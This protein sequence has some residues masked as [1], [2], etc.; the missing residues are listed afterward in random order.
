[1]GRKRAERGL[2]AKGVEAGQ[3]FL[4]TMMLNSGK[5]DEDT[6]EEGQSESAFCCWHFVFSLSILFFDILQTYTV[7][8]DYPCHLSSL[9]SL[10]PLVF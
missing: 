8:S 3:C 10:Q 5:K 6:G 7:R 1:M 2:S 4:Q 9:V